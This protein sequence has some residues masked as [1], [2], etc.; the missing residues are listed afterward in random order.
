MLKLSGIRYNVTEKVN[1]G[2]L[3]VGA[4]TRWRLLCGDRSGF[5]LTG[6]LA[7]RPTK[8]ETFV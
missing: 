5:R 1:Q 2:V 6:H 8:H 7:L 3:D 4:I